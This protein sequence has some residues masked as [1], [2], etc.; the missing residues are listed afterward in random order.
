MI[1]MIALQAETIQDEWLYNALTKGLK[2][3]LTAPVLTLDPTKPEP[4]R[5]AE[6]IMDNFSR[7][8]CKCIPMLIAPGNLIQML[9]PKDEVLISVLFQYGKKDIHIRTVIQKLHHYEPDNKASMQDINNI[10][11]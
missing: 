11:A 2:E 10:E 9:L 5:R 8:D 6:M 3:C 1:K 7:K 4:I